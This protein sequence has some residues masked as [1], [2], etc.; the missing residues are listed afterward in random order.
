MIYRQLGAVEKKVIDPSVEIRTIHDLSYPLGL[1]T[2]DRFIKSSAPSISYEY[3]TAL[4]RRNES[5]AKMHPQKRICMFKGDVK[6]AFRYLMTHASH[7]HRMAAFI[8]EFNLLI[9]DLAVPFGW[10]GSPSFYNAFGCAISWLMDKNS[11]APV[12]NSS[13]EECFFVCEWIDDHIFIEC[14]TDDRLNLAEATLRHVM[15]AVLGPR[16]TNESKFS[17]WSTDIVALGLRWDIIKHTVFI[18]SD[19]VPKALSRV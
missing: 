16:S 2:N 18:P 7:V 6:G 9:I 14:D 3:V 8:K 11:P 12:S 15:L 10:S 17:S 19:K 5:L 1:S 4:A 13:D